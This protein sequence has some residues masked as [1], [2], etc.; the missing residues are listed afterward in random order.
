MTDYSRLV[1]A[2]DWRLDKLEAA[3]ASTSALNRTHDLVSERNRLERFARFCQL[4][5]EFD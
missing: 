5:Q 2:A 3:I 1:M 4:A